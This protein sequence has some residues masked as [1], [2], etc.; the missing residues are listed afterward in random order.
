[1]NVHFL[2]EVDRVV[3]VLKQLPCEEMIYYVISQIVR[4]NYHLLTVGFTA[5][6]VSVYKYN[7]YN[8][9]KQGLLLESIENY[10][11]TSLQV[12]L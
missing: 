8:K 10:K 6:R 9:S 12:S 3:N 7:R 11:I 5:L 1:M 4:E 2:E